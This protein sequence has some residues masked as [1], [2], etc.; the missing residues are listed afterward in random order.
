MI[1]VWYEEKTNGKTREKQKTIPVN[2]FLFPGSSNI[3]RIERA[4]PARFSS[5]GLVSLSFRLRTTSLKKS[6]RTKLVTAT[7]SIFPQRQ[8]TTRSIGFTLMTMSGKVRKTNQSEIR[9]DLIISRKTDEI[10]MFRLFLLPLF[11]RARKA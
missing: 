1:V 6:E 3:L 8:W 2:I 4:I 5:S 9:D 11:P 7:Y 10:V